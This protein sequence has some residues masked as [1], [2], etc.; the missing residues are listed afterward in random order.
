MY[1][2][3]PLTATKA[4]YILT[5]LLTYLLTSCL[6]NGCKTHR[7]QAD[8][9]LWYTALVGVGVGGRLAVAAWLW[10]PTLRGVSFVSS[11]EGAQLEFRSSLALAFDRV[12]ASLDAVRAHAHVA[13]LPRDAKARL[14]RGRAAADGSAHQAHLRRP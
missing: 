5:Y 7:T 12:S 1:I 8:L 2:N 6:R 10:L 4:K 11:G 3:D 14:G 13:L 9:E